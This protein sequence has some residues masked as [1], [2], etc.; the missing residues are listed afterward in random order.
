MKREKNKY[1]FNL[2]QYRQMLKSQLNYVNDAEEGELIEQLNKITRQVEKI[3]NE[4]KSIDL[5]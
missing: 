2:L 5:K 1:E 3:I 4:N